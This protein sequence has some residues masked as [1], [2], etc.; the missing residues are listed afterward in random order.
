MGDIDY[1]RTQRVTNLDMFI[2]VSMFLVTLLCDECMYG[3]WRALGFL[4]AVY[5]DSSLKKCC[6][7][8][9]SETFCGYLL[10]VL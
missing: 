1:R 10:A 9:L 6:F 5:M 3:F 4:I 7:L 2:E 8:F